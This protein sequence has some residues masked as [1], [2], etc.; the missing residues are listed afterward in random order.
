MLAEARSRLAEVTD[1]RA[2]FRQT[3]HLVASGLDTVAAGTVELA[4]NGR[5][6][7]LYEGDD[8]QQIISD[9]ETLWFYQIRDSTVLR[10]ELASLPPASRLALDMLG[11][12][13]GVEEH[14]T[15]TSCDPGCL[16]L[17]P[18]QSQPDL[19]RLQVVLGEGQQ[20]VRSVTTEDALGNRTRV[21]F[22]EV[23]I[24]PR[25]PAEH[26]LFEPPAG[27]QVLDMEA[28]GG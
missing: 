9:G 22:S 16:E 15:L 26:F 8:P 23:E 24:D 21:E 13:V 17:V 3:S 5:M 4:S 6:R 25:L 20:L 7:W 1:L 27:V 11:G 10:R 18:Q 19:S 28:G 2:R 12:F 14:F